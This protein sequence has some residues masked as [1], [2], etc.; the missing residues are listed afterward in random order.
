LR[1]LRTA[2]IRTAGAGRDIVEATAPAVIE[3]LGKQRVLTFAFGSESAGVPHEWAAD[4]GRAGVSFLSDL[5]VRTTD[6]IARQVDAVRRAGDIVVAS[7]HW[8]GNWGY[9]ISRAE[10]DFAHRLVDSAGVNVV[11]GH[12]SHHPKGIEVYRSRPI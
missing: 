12:S 9:E 7:I 6:A 8:G 11:H 1:A 3:L 10:R 4:T 5:S 2:G